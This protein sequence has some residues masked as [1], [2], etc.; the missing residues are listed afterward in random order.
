M[1]VHIGGLKESCVEHQRK[2]KEKNDTQMIVTNMADSV[3]SENENNTSSYD[4]H[5]ASLNVRGLNNFKKRKRVFRWIRKQGF[6]ITFLQE[7]Y[8]TKEV[9]NRWTNEWGGKVFFSHGTNHSKGTICLVR[10]G[11]DLEVE[12]IKC[13][14]NGRFIIMKVK[15]QEEN[16]V[17]VNLYMPNMESQ[18]SLFLKDLTK[19]MNNYG[20]QASDNILIG[21]D[22][23]STSE[24]EIDR[25]SGNGGKTQKI[26]N[27]IK[28]FSAEFGLIDIWRVRNR[29]KKQFTY[30][31]KD[32]TIQSRLDYWLTSDHIQELLIDANII[33][34]PSPDHSAVTLKVKHLPEISKG[35][36]FWKFNTSLLKENTFKSQFRNLYKE[37]TDEFSYIEDKRVHWELLKYKI[38]SFSISYSKERKRKNKNIEELL[39]AK[40]ANLEKEIAEKPTKK[41]EYNDTVF[42]LRNIQ[43]E[44]TDGAIVR[45]RVRWFEE[46]ETS[47]AYFFNLEKRNYVRKHIKSLKNPDGSI[48]HDPPKILEMQRTFYKNLYSERKTNTN[49]TYFIENGNIPKLDDNLKNIC[50]S[51]VTLAECE[52]IIKTFQKSK[53]PGNDGLPIELYI[54]FWD[55]L[56]PSL[57]DCYSTS[58]ALE[59]LSVSQR[60]AV[61]TL[62]EKKNKDRLLLKNWRPIS[63]LNVDY[64]IISKVIAT[65]IKSVLPNLIHPDQSGYVDG[66]NIG[67]TIRAIDD[68][69]HY[70]DMENIPG[71][72]LFLDFEKAF[73]SINWKFMLEVLNVF[74]FGENLIKWIKIFYSNI[75]SCVIN[76]KI[77]SSYFDVERGV[78][79]GDPLSPYLFILAMELLA[80]NIRQDQ[81]IE[82]IDVAGYTQKICLY[83]D[84]TTC[85]MKDTKSAI[86]LF[87]V[88]K[89]FEK[90]S[91]FKIN[92]DKTEGVWIG[93]LK[94][95]ESRPFNIRWPENTVKGLGVHFS[96]DIT[97]AENE[98]FKPVIESIKNKYKIWKMR[99]L[100]LTGRILIAKTLGLSKILFLCGVIHVPPWVIKEI[101]TLT[102]NFVWNSKVDKVK[103]NIVVQTYEKGG[104]NMMD[105]TEMN[106][107][108]KIK[109]ITR[110][111]KGDENFWKLC[112]QKYMGKSNLCLFLQSNF[113]RSN[114]NQ[115]LPQFY[116][117]I[118]NV[119]YAIKTNKTKYIE[120]IWHQGIWYNEH[121]LI[122]GKE[123]YNRDFL[124][125]GLWTVRDLY[126]ENEFLLPFEKWIPY[127]RQPAP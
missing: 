73:D 81:N 67:E 59:E 114:I 14:T 82:G 96:H 88:L 27:L 16:F 115:K 55:L 37:W 92:K 46:G 45:S 100:S 58:Y 20:I 74:N 50:D 48:I 8:S 120:D 98:N 85:F 110:Y 78:R 127:L 68:I 119:W 71:L 89:D 21:G 126:D 60:Q 63:L 31:T 64:K 117:D 99:N 102:F 13:D 75:S 53:T 76:N 113:A 26:A 2:K 84:D 91:G 52:N 51:P 122:N 42:E 121:I 10:E 61:I 106:N 116:K 80:I 49:N 7:C 29:R 38:R 95:S 41:V 93:S 32:L 97:A 44:Q 56:G 107:S 39:E 118:I 87:K 17:L 4:F 28:D 94:H 123:L 125:A 23:N 5:M 86:N 9:E 57:L 69:I 105:L 11:F 90:V 83:A 43:K 62:L 124:H 19:C 30:R 1:Y 70:A 22:W 104:Q 65:R 72:L 33:P 54:A 18:Q 108:L 77:T 111:M 34:S 36:G 25:A 24:N 66:R 112:F 79:Q 109:W 47:S 3:E 15:I 101:N 103:R 40:V 6:N 35:P 12:E